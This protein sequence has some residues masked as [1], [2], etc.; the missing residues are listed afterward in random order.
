MGHWTSEDLHF[1]GLALAEAEVARGTTFPNPTVGAVLV[2]H[3]AVIATGV[4]QPGGRPHAEAMMLAAA[5]AGARGA[6]AYVTLEP[7]AHASPRG[8]ACTDSLIEAGL[9]RV[10]AAMIDPDPRT[11]GDGMARL[12]QAGITAETG[13]RQAEAEAQHQGFIRRLLTGMPLISESQDGKGFEARFDL[14]QGENFEDAARRMGALGYSRVWVKAGS[15]V[16]LA[17]AGRGLLQPDLA[18]GLQV[19]PA[20]AD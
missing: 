12:G 19:G 17:L 6:T 4:T 13:C 3:G 20:N 15:P 8:A 18:A 9:A 5:G 14:G 11:A 2:K 10:V 1:M 16:A 7:C